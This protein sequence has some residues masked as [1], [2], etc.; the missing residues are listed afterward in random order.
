MIKFLTKEE[1]TPKNIHD[2][3]IKIYGES[4]I[5]YTTVKKWAALFKSGRESLEDDPRP[6]RPKIFSTPENISRIHDIIKDDRRISIDKITDLL[7][8]THGT[9]WNI[10]Y[11]EL[12]MKKIST[13]WVPKILRSDENLTRVTLAKQFLNK[14][15]HKLC[16]GTGLEYS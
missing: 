8:I 7:D 12:D 3:M 15:C 14:Y 13:C 6:V 9:V 16:V 5:S 1:I 10:I 4:S 11:G 2:R